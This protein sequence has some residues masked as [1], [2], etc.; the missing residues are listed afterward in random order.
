MFCEEIINALQSKPRNSKSNCIFKFYIKPW[1]S[2]LETKPAIPFVS[3]LSSAFLFM[4]FL[5]HMPA[6]LLKVVATGSDL[7][8][9]PPTVVKGPRA[10]D[11]ML[12]G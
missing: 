7:N 6:T 3:R 5:F 4:Q 2:K 12:T 11:L 8:S 9:Q 1:C 10:L